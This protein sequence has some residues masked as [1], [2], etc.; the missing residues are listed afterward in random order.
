MITLKTQIKATIVLGILALVA[1]IGTHLA[2]TDIYH[3]EADTTL[4]WSIVRGCAIVLMIFLAA[5]MFTLWRTL[6]VFRSPAMQPKRR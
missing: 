1:G 2:L 4:E 5:A 6:S 3:G